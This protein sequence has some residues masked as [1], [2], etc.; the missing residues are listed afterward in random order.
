M[1]DQE[2]LDREIHTLGR[3]VKDDAAAMPS[4]RTSVNDRRLLSLQIPIRKARIAQLRDR[5]ALF[6]LGL[7]RDSGPAFSTSTCNIGQPVAEHWPSL[8]Q[9]VP[10]RGGAV[11]RGG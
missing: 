6:A 1:I 5:L 2:S 10:L 9:P 4:A 11:A 7:R 8:A 3:I